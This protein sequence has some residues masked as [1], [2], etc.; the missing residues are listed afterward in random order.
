MSD[1]E[2]LQQD[3]AAWL[4]T[5]QTAP[6]GVIAGM[7]T[8]ENKRGKARTLTFGLARTLDATLYIWSGKFL[9]LSSSRAAEDRVFTSVDEFK[10]YCHEAFGAPL[11]EEMSHVGV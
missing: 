5:W 6:Y 8:P 1:R 4:N 2:Q 9:Q 11:A 10:Q 3:L 7:H